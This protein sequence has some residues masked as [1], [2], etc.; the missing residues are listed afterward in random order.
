M[1]T[2]G[3]ELIYVALLGAFLMGILV[4]GLI[5]VWAVNKQLGQLEDLVDEV[6]TEAYRQV[7][8]K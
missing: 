1:K 3:C 4:G 2:E 7:R 5:S 8:G 6:L